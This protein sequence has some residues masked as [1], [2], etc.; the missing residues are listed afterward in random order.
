MLTCAKL[1][2]KQ[3]KMHNTFIPTPHHPTDSASWLTD[4][5]KRSFNKQFDQGDRVCLFCLHNICIN[6]SMKSPIYMYMYLGVA[7]LSFVITKAHNGFFSME[8]GLFVQIYRFFPQQLNQDCPCLQ[9]HPFRFPLY[10]PCCEKTGLRGFRPGPTQT[11]LC[12]HRW[13]E[14]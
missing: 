7:K 1:V 8:Q 9:P 14:A 10:E 11:G 12:S 3:R 5:K 2:L 6:F 4:F 13:L